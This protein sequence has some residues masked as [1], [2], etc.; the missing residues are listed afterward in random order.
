MKSATHL[1]YPTMARLLTIQFSRVLAIT[2]DMDRAKQAG[3]PLWVPAI[4]RMSRHGIGANISGL[5]TGKMTSGSSP[6]TMDSVLDQTIMAIH[7]QMHLK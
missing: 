6:Q 7:L 1:V 3:G 2:T 4:T 5:T